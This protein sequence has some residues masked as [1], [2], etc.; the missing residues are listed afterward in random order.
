MKNMETT[1]LDAIAQIRNGIFPGN[2][3]NDE[4][5]VIYYQMSNYNAED[6]K[7]ENGT[8]STITTNQAEKHLLCKNNL[9]LTAKGATYYCALY[10]PEQEEKAIACN[11][12]FIIKVTDERITPEFLCWYLNR[13]EIGKK[14]ICWSSNHF[15]VQ[16]EKLN[17][18]TIPL[19]TLEA[20]FLIHDIS[21]LQQ[22]SM[23]I[24]KEYFDA[25]QLYYYDILQ[26]VGNP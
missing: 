20:Q 16:K 24:Q 26:K 2:T 5:E 6:D 19:P 23:K 11:A 25:I 22:K 7:F 21:K 8:I 4:I 15:I 1:K 3:T 9:L 12:F 10:N 18:L 13:P 17:S 14:L